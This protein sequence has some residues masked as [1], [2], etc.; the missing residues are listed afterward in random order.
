M[1]GVEPAGSAG[2]SIQFKADNNVDGRMTYASNKRGQ[3]R[4]L[5]YSHDT[6]GLGHLR[7]CRAIAQS[8]VEQQSDLT[9]LILSGSP[10]IGSFDFRTR[11][12]FVRIPGVIKLRN[13]DYTSL[14]LHLDIEETLN[15]RSSIIKHTADA[16]DPDLFIVDKEPWGLRGEVR[17]TLE[18][19]KD[20]GTPL[21]LGLRDVMDEPEKL[22]PEW[23]RKNAVEALRD[24][25]DE[26]WVYGL[27][28]V[29]DP[30]SGMPMPQSVHAKTHYTGYLKRKVPSHTHPISTTD[31]EDPFI[32]VTAGGGGDGDGLMDWVL[33]AYESDNHLPYRALLV[34]G[35]FMPA[36][37]QNDF[38]ERAAE[39]DRVEAIT[40]DA[41]I[42]SM[43]ARAAGIVAMGGYNTFCEIL[44][45]DKRGLIVPRTEPRLEQFIRASRAEEL[46]MTAMLV[47]DG[48][49]EPEVMA[50]ALRRLPSQ[51]RPSEI[52]AAS[53]LDGL[54]E[55]NR[56][57][58]RW[59]YERPGSNISVLRRE[60]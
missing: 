41:R 30:Y 25:Y 39:L 58:H 36:E 47:D 40:F 43:M 50:D 60:A 26:I 33:K 16:F 37:L 32:L 21:V 34:L 24:V 3:K 27:Q 22:L 7:R 29:C 20:R 5:M 56:L 44:S 13:G 35:P 46:G 9:V 54:D 53:L 8:L 15:L 55:V 48:S 2:L 18:M 4:V 57:T 28:S 31:L 12:D 11:V 38:M 59:L 17:P 1:V 45:F 19:L 6:M 49:R 23:E 52:M 10:I 14:N 51:P 42:E